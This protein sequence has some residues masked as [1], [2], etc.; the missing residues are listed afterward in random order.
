M[1]DTGIV[2]MIYIG[3]IIIFRDIDSR[4]GICQAGCII[5][6]AAAAGAAALGDVV[7]RNS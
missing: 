4:R 3:R 2:A 6:C 5:I 1:L 7:K